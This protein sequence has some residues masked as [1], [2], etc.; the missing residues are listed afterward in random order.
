MNEACPAVS[1][2]S[3]AGS[4]IEHQSIS[5]PHDLRYTFAVHHLEAGQEPC[6]FIDIYLLWVRDQVIDPV[7]CN[8]ER[9]VLRII[10]NADQRQP[11]RLD[12][13]A[14]GKRGDFDL[15]LLSGQYL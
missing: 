11:F 7:E 15:G 8:F 3:W 14:D 2:R 10:D 9:V 4:G 13:A 5:E 6:G 12:L 1:P